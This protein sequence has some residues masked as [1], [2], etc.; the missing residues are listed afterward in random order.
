MTRSVLSLAILF[1]TLTGSLLLTKAVRSDTGDD[2]QAMTPQDNGCCPAMCDPLYEEGCDYYYDGIGCDTPLD[3]P[4]SDEIAEDA[5]PDEAGNEV[6]LASEVA[7]EENTDKDV[8]FWYDSETDEYYDY[9]FAA[10]DAAEEM[11]GEETVAESENPFDGPAVDEASILIEDASIAVVE[12]EQAYDEEEHNYDEMYDYEGEYAYESYKYTE[13]SVENEVEAITES[14][15]TEESEEEYELGADAELR[16]W[17]EVALEEMT[18][19]EAAEKVAKETTE[20]MTVESDDFDYGYEYWDEYDYYYEEA[21]VA[22]LVE[23]WEEGELGADAELECWIEVDL[24]RMKKVASRQPKQT[25]NDREAI[26]SLARTLDQVGTA[27]QA[28]SRELTE[29]AD[30]E[31]AELPVSDETIQR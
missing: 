11:T 6:E 10:D 30:A 22:E 29:M 12:E 3:A 2:A 9:E 14:V 23:N 15:A 7:A 4:A 26:L 1:A 16:Y 13:Q 19:V 20:A 5:V 24:E 27:L 28:L 21:E 18:D 17:M 31:V 25:D 8:D